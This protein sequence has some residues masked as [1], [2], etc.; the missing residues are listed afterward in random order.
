VVIGN[1]V[2]ATVLSLQLQVLPHGA[3]I[4]TYMKFAGRLYSR[5]NPQV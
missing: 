5:K 4:V 3:E 1:E 2:K